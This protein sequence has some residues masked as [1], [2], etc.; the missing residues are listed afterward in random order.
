MRWYKKPIPGNFYLAALDPSLGTGGNYS[1]IQ[2]FELPNFVQIAEWRNNITP[3]QQQVRI[4]RDMLKYIQEEIGQENTNHIYWSCENNTVGEAALIAI[5]DLGEE[6]FPGLFL[7]EPGK[8]GHIRKFRKGFNTTFGNKIPTCAR[9]KFLIEEN[10][11]TIFSKPLISELKAYI[12]SGFSFKA[13][14]GQSDDLV[15]ALL[16]LIRM[17]VVLAEWDQKIFDSISSGDS[18][19]DE[20]LILPMPIFISTIM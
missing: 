11:M 16:L 13:K 9:L 5:D 12:A 7:S 1:G 8:K 10:K 20:E 14:V 3:T 4:L 19:S 2:I 15:S 18:K 6:T 17:S